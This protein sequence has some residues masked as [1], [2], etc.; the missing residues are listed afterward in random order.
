MLCLRSDVGGSGGHDYGRRREGKKRP[1]QVGKGRR[2]LRRKGK[3]L[4]RK[5]RQRSPI[6][7]SQL[8]SENSLKKGP[9]LSSET[10][11]R[12]RKLLLPGHLCRVALEVKKSNSGGG[13]RLLCIVSPAEG[14]SQRESCLFILRTKLFSTSYQVYLPPRPRRMRRF[15]A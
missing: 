7:M 12:I 8:K 4:Q 5:D 13:G 9:G 10:D 2:R 1:S 3:G 14:K 6:E 11:H 15:P